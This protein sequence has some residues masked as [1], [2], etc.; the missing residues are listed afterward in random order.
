MAT[1]WS[2]RTTH[3]HAVSAT[4]PDGSCE[5]TLYGVTEEDKTWI[6]ATAEILA[7]PTGY[8]VRAC[9]GSGYLATQGNEYWFQDSPDGWALY[10][11]EDHAAEIL[12]AHHSALGTKPCEGGEVIPVF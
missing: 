9:N 12:E 8:A 7:T 6:E 2:R 5:A 10:A 11:T 3:G 4:R 1:L